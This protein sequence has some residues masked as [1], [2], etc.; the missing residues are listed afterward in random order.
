MSAQDHVNE[1][2]EKRLKIY[3]EREALLDQVTHGRKMPSAK[4]QK[5]TARI[6]FLG[7]E[8]K[9]LKQM[10]DTLREA[11]YL[12]PQEPEQLTDNERV[13]RRIFQRPGA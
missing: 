5:L 13:M 10:L 7:T 8:Q 4:L 2:E 12:A 11:G 3:N 1:L 6:N 9:E